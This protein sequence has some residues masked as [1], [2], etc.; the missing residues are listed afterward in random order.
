[1]GFGLLLVVVLALVLVRGVLVSLVLG[2]PS[3]W[4]LLLVVS[5]SREIVPWLFVI[6]FVGSGILGVGIKFV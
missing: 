4:A 5:S 1:L 2:R 3:I 6:R